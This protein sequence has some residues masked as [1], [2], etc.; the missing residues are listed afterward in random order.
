MWDQHEVL[1]S[2]KSLEYCGQ[3][4]ALGTMREKNKTI[5]ITFSLSW[6]IL[7]LK[8]QILTLHTITIFLY[9]INRTNC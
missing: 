8:E 4:L 2:I 3:R 6:L 1:N 9:N 5:I 7:T